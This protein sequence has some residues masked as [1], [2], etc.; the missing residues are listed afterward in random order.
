[1][2]VKREIVDVI[3]NLGA[4]LR[5]PPRRIAMPSRR[6]VSI[7]STKDASLASSQ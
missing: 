3:D 6:V 2:R 1:M 5:L 7:E 4:E